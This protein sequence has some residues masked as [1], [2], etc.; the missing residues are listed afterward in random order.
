M[1]RAQSPGCGKDSLQGLWA[2]VKPAFIALAPPV[3]KR[4]P[5]SYPPTLARRLIAVGVAA[6]PLPGAADD[7]LQAG[8]L[9]FPPQL[10]LDGL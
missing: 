3:G 6:V 2:L 5:S 10:A 8:K 7:L 9:G 1:R 4:A